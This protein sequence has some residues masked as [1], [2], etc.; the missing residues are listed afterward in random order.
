MVGFGG[1]GA[2]KILSEEDLDELFYGNNNTELLM[3]ELADGTMHDVN[4]VF[5]SNGKFMPLGCFDR[6]FDKDLP[7]ETGGIYPSQLNDKLV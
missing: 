1:E 3:E 5:D 6:F 7:V 4:A 2:R